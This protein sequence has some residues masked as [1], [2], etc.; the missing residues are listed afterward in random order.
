MMVTP[1]SRSERTI[2]H[3]SRRSSTST[4]AVGSSRKRI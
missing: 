1:V 3:M 2:A 4:P